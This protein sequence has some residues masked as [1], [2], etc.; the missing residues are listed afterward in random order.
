MKK[1]LRPAIHQVE[2]RSQKGTSKSQAKRWSEITEAVDTL[3]TTTDP[4]K[5]SEAAS[6]LDHADDKNKGSDTPGK[7]DNAGDDKGKING[8]ETE[9]SKKKF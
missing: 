8:S 2:I 9:K 7:S 6:K 4:Q 3:K 1:L 5:R